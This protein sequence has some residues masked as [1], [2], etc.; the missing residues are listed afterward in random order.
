MFKKIKKRLPSFHQLL[1]LSAWGQL[2]IVLTLAASLI[3][4]LKFFLFMLSICVMVYYW[5]EVAEVFAEAKILTKTY[6]RIYA[7]A[8]VF[9]MILALALGLHQIL[10]LIELAFASA[11]AFCLVKAYNVIWRGF[12]DKNINLT[13]GTI[14]PA[15]SMSLSIILFQLNKKYFWIYV[16]AVMLLY[17]VFYWVAR[18]YLERQSKTKYISDM[19]GNYPGDFK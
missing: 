17:G 11:P 9:Y 2:L 12:M 15:A 5:I 13:W 3:I 1:T 14:I 8:A 4:N 19:Y 7:V 6:L 16:A 10:Y 18:F